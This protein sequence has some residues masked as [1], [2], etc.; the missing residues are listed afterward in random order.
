M[1]VRIGQDPWI[2][3]GN[4]H[5]LPVELK[6]FLRAENITHIGHIVDPQ[7]TTLFQQVWKLAHRLKIPQK[8]T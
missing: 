4:A 7:H 8:W 6:N 1:G 2:G 3:Y 5:K